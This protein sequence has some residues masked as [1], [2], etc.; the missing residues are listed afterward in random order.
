MAVTPEGIHQGL[1]G[2]RILS[3]GPGRG[4]GRGRGFTLIELLV[5][6][7]IIAL[8]ISILLPSL[9]RAK[10]LANRV[11]CAANLRGAGQSLYIYA[12]ENNNTL[13][14]TMPPAQAY[15]WTN[16][17][18]GAQATS[19]TS[20]DQLALAMP[21]RRPGSPIA[22]MWI[23][24]LYNQAPAKMF[25]C[26]SDRA[27]AGP[28]QRVNSSGMLFDNFQDEFQVSYSIVYPWSGGGVSPAWR[29]A[30]SSSSQALMS[31]MAP[32]SGDGNKNTL[33][34][35]G[36]GAANSANHE[37][38][39]QNV[40]YAD[41]HVDWQTNPY[42]GDTQDNLFTVG[43]VNSQV[44]VNNLNALPGPPA[45]PQDIVMVPVRR[46]SDGVMGN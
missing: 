38:K 41:N 19:Y 23:L 12:Y 14:V 45:S 21:A 27:I 9:G 10:E 29:Y 32:L 39:G 2:G 37:D 33:A 35:R 31:D 8:L 22:S 40:S 46:A 4:R 44:P 24:T 11:Y 36:S 34:P 7:A 43:P 20:G 15:Q 28:A 17:F 30:S 42:N 1:A 3:I 13:P 18:A 16:G 25:V 6:V 26:K 5:V